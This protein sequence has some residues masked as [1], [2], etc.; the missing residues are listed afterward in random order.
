M[1]Q[2]IFCWLSF[3]L[4]IGCAKPTYKSTSLMPEQRAKLLLK[5]LTLEEKVSLMMDV[6][7]PVE[8]LGIKPYNW[9][10]EALHGVARAGIATVFPQPIGMAASFSPETVYS[11]FDAVSD[12]ARAKNAY[13]ASQESYERYQGLT[14]WTPTVNIYRDPRWGRGIETYGEDPYLTSR[15]GV[16]VVKALQGG[17]DG[18]YDKLHACA[19]HFAVH[20]GPEWN[21][22]SFNVEGLSARDLYETYLPPFEALVKEAG[23][24]EVMCA[25]NR[26]EGEP[27]CG[28]NRLLTQILRN[29]WGYD[30]IILSDCW[31]IADFY[32]ERGHKTHADSA[33]ASA[34]AVLSGTDLECGSSYKS[35]SKAI[36]E[37]KIDESAV[38]ASV[39]RI[40]KARFALGEMDDPSEVSW[41]KI[42]YSV[43]ASDAHS[44]LSLNMARKSM[45]LLQNNHEILPL[46]RG[47]LTVAIMG[48]NANDSVMQW[49]NYNGMPPHTVTILDGVRNALGAND[50]LIYEQG[51]SWLGNTRMESVFSQCK[52]AKGPGFTARYWNNTKHQGDV[53]VITQVT[54]PFHFCTSG[55]TVFAPGVN[56]TDFSAT[57]NSVF[58]PK[59]SG[60][61]VFEIYAYGSGRLRI[62]GKLVKKFSNVHGGRSVNYTMTVKAGTSYK[63]SLDYEYYRSDA[64]LNFDIGFKQT[65]NIPASVAKV[66]DADVVIFAGG[67]SPMLEGEEMGVDLPGFKKG[68]RTEIELPA[69]Q[70]ELVKALHRAGKKIVFVNCSGSPIALES[71][72]QCCEAILQAW[73]PG[74]EGGTAVADVLFGEYNPAGRLPVTFYRN[75]SQLPDFE[76]YDMD[77]R[78]YRYMNQQP[79]F[80]F[81]YGL[82]YTN[83]AYDKPVL[84]KERI[85]VG[86]QQTLTVHV[87]NIGKCDGDEVVQVYLKR[88]GDVEGPI[89]TLRAFRRVHI[90]AGASAD[91][92]FSL[93]DKELEWWDTESN[94]MRVCRGT[95]DIMVGGSSREKDL[96]YGCF[97]IE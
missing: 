96:Q 48:P 61:V 67:I 31:A 19:K 52:S 60:E 18:K 53:D 90:A 2:N 92:E 7:K 30:G 13:Y 37:G 85:K 21:R 75:L 66:K 46:K 33:S 72:S 87:S 1:K 9:W 84:G 34:S 74:Q 24:K 64:L 22:H 69:I 16:Q 97:I 47:G 58:T 20:S 41:T 73:Y 86:E 44:A 45:T 88:Q 59:Q 15:M 80:P 79:L 40:L 32:T 56:L 55:A 81:G 54:T 89:K 28:S 82:S 27:C 10:N 3:L 57:Y 23:V 71:E 83:F 29:D 49:G 8:R 26:F 76:N 5:E 78:T 95:Y 43:V 91:V 38:D 62:D 36:R 51:C 42:P 11:V 77:G 93:G 25:Y 68:D 70:R 4:L 94:T 17:N 63:I 12:E 6:S 65:V 50:K 39:L 35:L 14:M